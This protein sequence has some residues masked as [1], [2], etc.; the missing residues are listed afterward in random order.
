M[1][2]EAGIV[3]C[4]T[5]MVWVV[6]AVA[7]RWGSRETYTVETEYTAEAKDAAQARHPSGTRRTAQKTVSA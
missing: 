1:M 7:D 3:I 4:A 6:V 2:L 5:L